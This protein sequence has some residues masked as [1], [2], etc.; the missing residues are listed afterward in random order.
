MLM[1]CVFCFLR[2]PFGAHGL[3]GKSTHP[4][5]WRR[6]YTMYLENP[7]NSSEVKVSG[8]WKPSDDMRN[9]K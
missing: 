4:D 9:G 5:I 7:M 1:C 8:N 2:H 6:V 3:H